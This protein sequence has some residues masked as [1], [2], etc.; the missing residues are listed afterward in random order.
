MLML[1]HTKTMY[2]TNGKRASP[3]VALFRYSYLTLPHMNWTLHSNVSMALL[4]V[5]LMMWLQ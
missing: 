2:S 3:K 1:P 5:L 4:F